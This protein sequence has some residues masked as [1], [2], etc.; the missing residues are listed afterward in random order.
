MIA[1]AIQ[2]N[3]KIEPGLNIVQCKVLN[4]YFVSHCVSVYSCMHNNMT[5]GQQ[6]FFTLCYG[7]ELHSSTL[8]SDTPCVCSGGGGGGGLPY[9]RDGNACRLA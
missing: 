2:R 7:T 8:T 9:E 3:K 1:K 6:A 5:Y 4:N